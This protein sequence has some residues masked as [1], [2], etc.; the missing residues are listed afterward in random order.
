[1]HGYACQAL[2]W[3]RHVNA[4]HHGALPQSYVSSA[5]VLAV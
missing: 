4:W 1:M 2:T 5:A 3:Q